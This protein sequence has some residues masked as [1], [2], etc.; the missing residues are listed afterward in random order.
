MTGLNKG[1][2]TLNK[3]RAVRS[4][5]PYEYMGTRKIGQYVYYGYKERG[6]K[7]WKI[8]RENKNDD[9]AWQYCYGDSGW[10]AAWADVTAL[11]YGDPPDDDPL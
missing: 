10:T 3:V 1:I 5:N 9:A 2:D 4:L 6:G 11:V 8:V 7:N